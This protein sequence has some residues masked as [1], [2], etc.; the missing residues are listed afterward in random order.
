MGLISLVRTESD[1]VALDLGQ[2]IE[3]LILSFF[4]SNGLDN[5]FNS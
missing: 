3:L 2:A 1:S 5:S 4:M